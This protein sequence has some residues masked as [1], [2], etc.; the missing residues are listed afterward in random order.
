MDLQKMK[1][2]VT[3]QKK[4]VMDTPFVTLLFI[5]NQEY[6]LAYSC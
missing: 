3:G 5:W 2:F 4:G 6:A 1:T